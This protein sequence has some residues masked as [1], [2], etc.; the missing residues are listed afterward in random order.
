[1]DNACPQGHATEVS[2]IVYDPAGLRPLNHALVYVP[3]EPLAE[4]ANGLSCDQCSVPLTGR[5]I[6]TAW[7]DASGHF[8]LRDVPSGAGVRLVMQIGKWRREVILP[9]VEACVTNTIAD[10][11]LTR[12]PR[13]QSEGHIPQFAAVTGSSDALECLL[14]RIGIADQEFSSD[15]GTGRV[16]LYQ[17]GDVDAS[18]EGGGAAVL[19]PALGGEA[20]SYAGTLWSNPEKLAQYDALVMSCE[21]GSY[22]AAKAAYLQNIT[23]YADRGGRLFMSHLQ[24]TWLR[25]SAYA[26]TANYLGPLLPPPSPSWM[27]IDTASAGGNALADWLQVV[28]TSS[29]RGILRLAEAQHSI[30]LVFDPTQRWIYLP[31]NFADAAHRP[32]VDTLSFYTPL[33]SPLAKQC[34]RVV[35][36]DFHSTPGSPNPVSGVLSGGDRSDPTIPFPDGCRIDEMS[37]DLLASE[38]MLFELLSCIPG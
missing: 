17:G 33:A 2:G 25:R 12:L 19:S 4:L 24:E 21:G 28:G 22:V 32:A 37:A 8:T 11:D 20:L 34:G 5:P 16:H 27:L 6:A 36:D 35:L 15:L 9:N 23:S 7:T 3:S 1:V 29:A 26:S 10:R 13:T 18:H 14:R 38:F 31:E 30:D